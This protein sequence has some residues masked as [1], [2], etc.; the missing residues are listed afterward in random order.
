MSMTSVA[1]RLT[2]EQEASFVR[3]SPFFAVDENLEGRTCWLF[4]S[5]KPL[6][7]Q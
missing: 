5:F 4:V 3:C 7:N 6:I 2:P 1:Q